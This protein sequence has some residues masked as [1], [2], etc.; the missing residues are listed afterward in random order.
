MVSRMRRAE[1]GKIVPGSIKYPRLRPSL[2]L[3]GLRGRRHLDRARLNQSGERA[4]HELG[5]IG[6]CI[7][8]HD[9]ALAKHGLG[10]VVGVPL[11][12]GKADQIDADDV[13]GDGDLA[14][15]VGLDFIV[16]LVAPGR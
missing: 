12:G 6:E 11:G 8:R 10:F 5:G 13:A 14:D 16:H 2:R 15:S 9:D 1:M 3:L 4:F 7:D